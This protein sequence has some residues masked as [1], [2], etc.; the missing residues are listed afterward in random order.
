MQKAPQKLQSKNEKRKKKK[1]LALKTFNQR[2]VKLVVSPKIIL[3]IFNLSNTDLFIPNFRIS[4][5]FISPNAL[6]ILITSFCSQYQHI[7]KTN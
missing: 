1:G 2:M 3:K 5:L 7:T 4:Y 6:K